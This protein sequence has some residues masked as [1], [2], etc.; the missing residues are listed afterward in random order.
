M[1]CAHG[2]QHL[3]PPCRVA[4]A[5]RCSGGAQPLSAQCNGPLPCRPL[6]LYAGTLAAER[7]RGLVGFVQILLP[8]CWARVVGAA[9]DHSKDSGLMVDFHFLTA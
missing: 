2:F 6:R 8:H 9:T 1:W 3:V 4:I 7:S 5:R